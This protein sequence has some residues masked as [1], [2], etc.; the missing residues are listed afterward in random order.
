MGRRKWSR[1]PYPQL[2]NGCGHAPWS[3]HRCYCGFCNW[4]EK[5]LRCS[6]LLCLSKVIQSCPAQAAA[7]TG[8]STAVVILQIQPD[9]GPVHVLGNFQIERL[10]RSLVVLSKLWPTISWSNIWLKRQT[11][12]QSVC[13]LWGWTRWFTRWYRDALNPVLHQI[14][15]LFPYDRGSIVTESTHLLS[16]IWNSPS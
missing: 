10:N 7:Y 3:S 4:D 1:R 12:P 5:K 8:H 13:P 14:Q 9:S 16:G 2:F 6:P 15:K 11:Q